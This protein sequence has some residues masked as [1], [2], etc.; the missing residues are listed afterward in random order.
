M[1]C[2]DRSCGTS[3]IPGQGSEVSHGKGIG[4]EATGLGDRSF[5]SGNSRKRCG[6]WAGERQDALRVLA[7]PGTGFGAFPNR[8]D[9]EEGLWVGIE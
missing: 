8:R 6:W 2:N 9:H 1:A 4:H 7:L 3:P 5:C